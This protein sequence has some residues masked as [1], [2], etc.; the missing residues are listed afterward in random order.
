MC[1]IKP[2]ANSD[3]AKGIIAFCN[4]APALAAKVGWPYLLKGRV[5]YRKRIAGCCALSALG[6]V[7]RLLP[8]CVLYHS[9]LSTPFSIHQ[10]IAAFDALSMRLLGIAL[11]SL[12]SGL[13]ELTFLQLSTTYKSQAAGEAVGYFASG[14]GCAGL[15][16]AGLWWVL[17]GLGVREGVGI[18]SVSFELFQVLSAKMMILKRVYP[19]SPVRDTPCVRIPSPLTKCIRSPGR[20][21]VDCLSK[22]IIFDRTTRV[23]Y[24]V[25]QIN[26]V[27]VFKS[28]WF[29]SKGKVGASK[30]S[31]F[32]IHA[33]AL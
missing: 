28:S 21:H 3:L 27:W 10:V 32:S 8:Y 11:A 4:I 2:P 31:N 24:Y 12:S 23:A 17:R 33:T 29:N 7:V 14:T 26:H 9:I 20:E 15:L 30:A 25:Y 18:S 13:G 19:D 6:M 16:G 1:L 5:R 22:V